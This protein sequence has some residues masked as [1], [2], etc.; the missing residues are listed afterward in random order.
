MGGPPIWHFYGPVVIY[1][2]DQTNNSVPSLQRDQIRT[3]S[4]RLPNPFEGSGQL[5]QGERLHDNSPQAT[6]M[7]DQSREVRSHSFSTIDIHRSTHSLR[8]QQNPSASGQSPED[9]LRRSCGTQTS[10]VV[11]TMAEI[12]RP[13]NLRSGPDSERSITSQAYPDVSDP[14]HPDRRHRDVDFTSAK[15][16]SSSRVVAGRIQ[17]LERLLFEQLQ[18]DSSGVCRRIQSRMGSPSGG[19]DNLRAVVR[20]PATVAHQ[21]FGVR[22]DHSGRSTLAKSVTA[23][24]THDCL[25]QQHSC[26]VH[27]PSGRNQIASST[28]TDLPLLQTDRRHV[29]GGESSS[30]CRLPECD[31]GCL[32][33]SSTS[34]SDRVEVAS[35]RIPVTDRNDRQ[36]TDGLVCH[37][38]KQTTA[39]VCLPSTRSQC[40]GSRRSQPVMGRV[41]R[42]RF[43]SSGSSPKSLAKD[44]PDKETVH[45][46]DRAIMASQ[47]VVSRPFK[48]RRKTH[49]GTP[50]VAKSATRSLQREAP[51]KSRSVPST[52]LEHLQK[53][54]TQKGYSRR[55]AEAVS[56]ALRPSTTSLY[57]N[58]WQSF[59]QYCTSKGFSAIAATL[60]QVADYLLFLRQKK[61][62]AGSTISTYLAALNTVLPIATKAPLWKT[63]VLSS[64]IRGFKLEDQKKKFRPPAW[65]LN[66]VLTHLR[67]APYEPLEKA[68]FEDLTLKTCFLLSLA[69][70]ARVSEIHALD[71]TR[72]T[73]DQ[74]H[75]GQA[76]LGLSWDFLAKNQLPGQP[77]R[78]FHIPPL[79]Q[80]LAS[81]EVEDLSL[82]PVRALKQYIKI[83]AS[84]RGNRQRL[85]LPLS[86]T[87]KNDVTRNTVSFWLRSTI[88]RAY[89][90]A[91]LPHPRA[92]NPHEIRALASTMALHSNKSVTAIMEGCFWRSSTVF[93]SHYLRNIS[94]TDVEGLHSFGPLVVAQQV[95]KPDRR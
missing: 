62:L 31:S 66:V 21:Q 69:T 95:T 89:D 67:Q 7:A 46:F 76:H 48:S 71:V 28:A 79:S 75:N 32:I 6:G 45:D 27:K 70:A 20:R 65:D 37:S 2:G 56:K 47:T 35:R 34:E 50:R 83:S 14:V 54:L 82:C 22:G 40:G 9:S 30:H 72:I 86:K 49:I 59:Q 41:K 33:A 44:R 4:G 58:K 24:Q 43:S 38:S 90:K 15:T 25:G 53:S 26:V 13:A 5:D 92:H 17:H 74:R 73:F 1:T 94:V 51:S 60:P 29:S 23:F 12:T 88:L 81:K 85:F 11:T 61:H 91:G 80:I 8:S 55:A 19:T 84:R 36:T 78:Q 3:V 57:D 68:S 77:D 10:L 18:S 93:S 16:Q 64:I 39:A 87:I 42:V 63:K 52:R